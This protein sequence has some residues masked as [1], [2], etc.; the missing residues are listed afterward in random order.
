M[1][2]VRQPAARHTGLI[3]SVL[4]DVRKTG[5]STCPSLLRLCKQGLEYYCKHQ[6][7][8][9]SDAGAKKQSAHAEGFNC[10]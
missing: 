8:Y 3:S 5:R 9:G 4:L 6:H 1:A 10:P 7:R 2:R